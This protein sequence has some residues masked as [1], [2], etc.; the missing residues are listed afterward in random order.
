MEDDSK[1]IS[2]SS[3]SLKDSILKFED[4]SK[5]APYK[6]FMESILKLRDEH[7][8][9]VN[10]FILDG[11][12]SYFFKKGIYKEKLDE[13]F[14]KFLAER[15]ITRKVCNPIIE[16]IDG[17]FFQ[18]YC[19]GEKTVVM[20]K[21]RFVYKSENIFECISTLEENISVTVTYD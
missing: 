11:L 6:E 15:K 8:L 17:C 20:V 18:K 1:I 9:K 10:R 12:Y 4:D 3:L 21:E 7:M 5:T 14:I 13:S 16:D 19:D 2:V